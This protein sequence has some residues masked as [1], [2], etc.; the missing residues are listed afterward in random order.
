MVGIAS[1]PHPARFTAQ[2]AERNANESIIPTGKTEKRL[3]A[4]MR[5]APA[6]FTQ[7]RVAQ[8]EAV[9]VLPI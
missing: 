1:L 9:L 3:P 5:S 7:H 2:V 8:S 6:P 4:A